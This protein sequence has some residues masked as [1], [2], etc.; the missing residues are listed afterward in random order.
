MPR[1]AVLSAVLGL[2]LWAWFA[3]TL[4]SLERYYFAA[5]V[6]SSLHHSGNQEQDWAVWM[7]KTGP[8]SKV[9]IAD[10]QDLTANAHGTEPFALSQHALAKGW[11]G[12]DHSVPLAYAAGSLQPFLQQNFFEDGD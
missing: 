4:S 1:I 2:L 5:Y 7:L 11:T 9:E 12:V 8:K 3:L 6:G 10:P